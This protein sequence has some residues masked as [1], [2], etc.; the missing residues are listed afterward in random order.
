MKK[1]LLQS[2]SLTKYE[3]LLPRIFVGSVQLEIRDLKGELA[4]ALGTAPATVQ[5]EDAAREDSPVVAWSEF[6]HGIQRRHLPGGRVQ[7]RCALRSRQFGQVGWLTVGYDAQF[8]VPVSTAPEPLRR[9]FVDATA[10]LQEELELL[11]ECNQMAVELT[12]RYEELNL[13]YAT[14]DQVEY[15]EEGREALTRLV[16]NCAD[17]L[18]VA[19]AALICRDSN[20]VLHSSRGTFDTEALLEILG[21]TVYTRV[22]S[23]VSS[24]ILNAPDDP[25]RQRLFAGREENL[26][27]YPI[28]DDH[29]TAIGLIA[30]IAR[31]DKHV[32]SNGDRN[33]LEVMAKKAS[34]IIHT[35]H[36][37]LTGL[38]NR[39]GFESSLVT[40]VSSA[41][42]KNQRHC[43][44]HID[45]DQLH[46]I[47]DLMG[48]QEGDALIRRV[49]KTLRAVLRDSDFLA[50][51]GG[52]EFAVLLFSCPVEQGHTIAEKIRNAI[53]ELTVISANRQLD[54]SASIGV[55]SI[56]PETEGIV[57]V[58]ASAEI[59]CKMAKEA[60]R[61]RI[62]V[63]AEDNTS[64]V[65]RSEEIEWIGRVQQ[66]LRDDE[67]ELYCQAV[68]PLAETSRAPHFEI[69]VRLRGDDGNVLLPGLFLPAAERYQ[70]M[71]Q[72]DRWVIRNSLRMLGSNWE[73]I[74]AADAVF[75][76]NLSGQ[77]LTDHSFLLFVSD[78]LRN[79]K[80]P[81]QNICFEIT[82]TA[83]ISNID[84]AL[85]FMKEMRGWG[86]RFALD[87]FGA[88][89][90]SFGYLKVLPVDYLKIDG[91]FVREV[92]TDR[93]ARSMVEAMCQIGRTMGLQ[94]IAEFVGDEETVE[95]LRA[96]GVDY[97]QGFYIGKPAPLQDT[98]NRLRSAAAVESA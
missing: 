14:K 6:G 39:S 95:V 96:M 76:V 47:N 75:C 48:H 98:T 64:L 15:L 11:S 10:F 62:Q 89:L 56:D 79:A 66:G 45:I 28:L 90:S 81:P 29:G 92:S 49:A 32:F 72:I 63:F 25:E 9:A 1:G 87:D 86:C 26:L 55:A 54:V 65:R 70:L 8:S 57:G 34:R 91:S 69:L 83:A 21:T 42:S 60:G 43:L 33:L 4:W 88:G 20:L 38:M 61:D 13:V 16:H 94:M 44:L 68:M 27:V 58:M 46:V 3:R 52:D 77:S 67:F 31:K 71:P 73:S 22:E 36:D 30:V 2:L 59:A 80:V 51:L 41:R 85:T 53:A 35:H 37:S 24:L 23:Q 5:Q 7:F 12:E 93:I 74:A 17:Y 50:R 82:E 97:A 78:E 18:D 19:L 84:E 40:A